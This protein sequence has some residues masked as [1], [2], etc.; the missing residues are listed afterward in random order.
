MKK[1][2]CQICQSLKERKEVVDRQVENALLKKSLGFDYDEV[3]KE[4]IMDTGQKVRHG[5][6]QELTEEDWEG[7]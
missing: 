4:R 6:Q 1:Q 2:Y 3:T 7:V 5:G